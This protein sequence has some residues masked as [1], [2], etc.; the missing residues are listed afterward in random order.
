MGVREACT[1]ASAAVRHLCAACSANLAT[2]WAL[3][4]A[5]YTAVLPLGDA[6]PQQLPPPPGHPP[7][8]P[9]PIQE[10]DVQAV[11]TLQ[12]AVGWLALAAG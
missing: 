4:E 8:P 12:A 2:R 1:A 7:P 6:A 9:P 3:V 10:S 5:L 11:R